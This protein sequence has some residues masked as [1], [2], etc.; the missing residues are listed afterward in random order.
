VTAV[1]AQTDSL[2][3]RLGGYDATAAVSDDFIARLATDPL[4]N[5]SV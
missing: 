5:S 1:W 4:I 3:K 2:Y